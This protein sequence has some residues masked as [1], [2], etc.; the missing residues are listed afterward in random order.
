MRGPGRFHLRLRPGRLI[1]ENDGPHG[2]EEGARHGQGH[3]VVVADQGPHVAQPIVL[4]VLPHGETLQGRLLAAGLAELDEA[5]C[6]G[7]SDLQIRELGTQRSRVVVFDR[8][9]RRPP[10]DPLVIEEVPDE[11]KQVARLPVPPRQMGGTQRRV[12]AFPDADR[13]FEVGRDLRIERRGD[14]DDAPVVAQQIHLVGE[15][16]CPRPLEVVID[17]AARQGT[18]DVPIAPIAP[19]RVRIGRPALVGGQHV[20]LLLEDGQNVR[21]GVQRNLDPGPGRARHEK[22]R[23]H[24]LHFLVGPGLWHGLDAEAQVLLGLAAKGSLIEHEQPLVRQPAEIGQDA[25]QARNL[26]ELLHQRPRHRIGGR[27]TLAV[28]NRLQGFQD[29]HYSC[30][31][32]LGW[33]VAG[34]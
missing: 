20:R 13:L 28:E 22:A 26:I 7:G 11:V 1:V 10:E 27:E 30:P 33:E 8:L 23:Q 18:E 34:P 19:V 32:A 2:D 15:E 16:R 17:T 21:A 4:G 31:P 6:H 9:G 12:G 14:R 5:V 24:P 3:L 29:A 25:G